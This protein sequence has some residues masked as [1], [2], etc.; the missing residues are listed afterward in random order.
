MTN[1]GAFVGLGLF[2]ISYSLILIIYDGARIRFMAPL[3][4]FLSIIGAI[5]LYYITQTK[6]VFKKIILSII[7]IIL[8]LFEFVQALRF[9]YLISQPY[10]RDESVEWIQ[11]NISQD[12]LILV[13]SRGPILLPDKK[14]L[15][16]QVNISPE[17]LTTKDIFLSGLSD[18]KYPIKNNFILR[19]GLVGNKF[20]SKEPLEKLLLELK[21]NYFVLFY[22]TPK[23]EDFISDFIEFE[24]AKK[25]GQTVKKFLPFKNINKQQRMMFTWA[26]ENPIIDLWNF[27]KLGPVI[28]IYELKW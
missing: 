23:P 1:A 9:I 24:L 15:E 11:N 7:I 14:S 18:D 12:K 22:T 16:L 6:I 25:Y 21:P 27:K 17:S 10:T 4:P 28:D 2:I 26:F 13:Q 5:F 8:L 19:L 3:T 20:Q